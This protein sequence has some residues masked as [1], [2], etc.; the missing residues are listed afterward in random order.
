MRPTSCASSPGI[1]TQV[2][3]LPSGGDSEEDIPGEEDGS[4][5]EVAFLRKQLASALAQQEKLVSTLAQ[6]QQI[7]VDMADTVKAEKSYQRS[8]M[9]VLGG[10]VP[11]HVEGQPASGFVS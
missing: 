2:P 11:E 7:M 1:W 9:L 6:Q 4:K 5:G 3:A 8:M 10:A